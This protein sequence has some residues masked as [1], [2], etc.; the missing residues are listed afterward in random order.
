MHMDL[1]IKTGAT[2]DDAKGADDAPVIGRVHQIIA[3]AVR[4]RASDIHIEPFEGELRIRYRV[5]GMCVKQDSPP[6]RLQGAVISRLKIIT[7]YLEGY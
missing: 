5:D 1:T 7:G 6:K 4:Q 2:D 3:N